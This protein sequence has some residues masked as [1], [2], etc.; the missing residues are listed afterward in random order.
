M[1]K[2]GENIY[3]RKDKRWEARYIKAYHPDGTPKYG[4]CY[5]KTYREAKPKVTQAKTALLTEKPIATTSRSRTPD[6]YQPAVAHAVFPSLGTHLYQKLR[7]NTT[8]AASIATSVP[9]PIAIPMSAEA[10]AGASFMP[11]PT[12]A[13]RPWVESSRIVCSFC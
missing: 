6:I 12:I 13:T 10:N 11:S 7:I 8:S 2:K 5:G 1:S 9:A 3:K 4:Y